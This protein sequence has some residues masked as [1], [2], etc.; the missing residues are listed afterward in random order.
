[1]FPELFQIGP[2]PIRSFGIGLALTFLFGV[3]YVKRIAARDK[4]PF[5]PY[6]IFAYIMIIGGV[7]GARLFYV[8]L[9]WSDFTNNLGA[10]YNP[11]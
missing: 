1:M 2:F 3:Y 6:L 10:I 8:I 7:V 9:H 5:E 11:F 4:R